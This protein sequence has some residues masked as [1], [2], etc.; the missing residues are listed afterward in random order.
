MSACYA[1]GFVAALPVSRL[2]LWMNAL[3]ISLARFAQL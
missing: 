3:G 2:R 1:P